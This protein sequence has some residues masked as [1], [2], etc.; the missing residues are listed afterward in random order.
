[1]ETTKQPSVKKNYIYYI[2]FEILNL[3]TPFITT[4]YVARVLGADGIGKYSYMSSIMAYFVLAAALGTS[5]Y[6][7]REISRHREDRKAYSQLFW[8]IELLSIFTS[9]VSLCIWCAVIITGK[10]NRWYYIALIPML[11]ASMTD[12]SWF[13]LGHERLKCIVVRNAIC[14]VA[15]IVFL[16]LLIKDK[17]DLL[18]YVLMNS[19]VQLLGSL[20]MW[21]YLPGM[22]ER[23][24]RKTLRFRKHF[25]ETLIYFVPTIATSVYTILDKTLIGLITGD[26]YQNGYYE[27]ASRVINVAKALV[28]YS[29]NTVMGTRI[30][31]LY[32]ENKIAEIKQRIQKSMDFIMLL[33]FGFVF[34][35]VSIAKSFVPVFF[36]EGYEPVVL[37][38]YLMAPL[39]LIIG[40]SNCLDSHYYTPCG[41][42]AKSSRYIII[43][44]ICNL[45]LNLI[46]IPRFY[47][48]G[49][50]IASVAAEL[51]ITVLYVVHSD[52]YM[53]FVQLGRMVY[54][55]L[56][57]GALM[58]AAVAGLP[59][60]TA[61]T[62]VGMLLLQVFTGVL[63]YGIV[64]LLFRDRL[65]LELIKNGMRVKAGGN[66]GR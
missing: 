46:L 6:G 62:G 14:K 55:R 3:V 8:E 2:S 44:A 60:I 23:V 32:A 39:I 20:S 57:A 49:A 36:G 56:I 45:C 21:T 33:G 54:K 9:M 61:W 28:F 13:F 41:Y 34:G 25:R 65:L 64:L 17:D 53:T 4:P 47:A 5:S 48:E 12:I 59:Y 35:I 10:E 51:L 7:S 37:L 19:V 63:I 1:M 27:Q 11:L 30:A 29:V 24:D 38:L 66:G 52:G 18:L 16:F 43:G 22:L 58:A 15:G 50:A 40:V 42:R 31:F 26:D